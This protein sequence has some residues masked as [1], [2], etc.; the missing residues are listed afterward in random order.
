LPSGIIIKGIGGFYYVESAGAIYECKA[1]GIFRRRGLVP[2]AGDRVDFSLTDDRKKVGCIDNILPRQSLLARPTVANVNQVVVV[3]SVKS[4]SPDFMLVD[5]LLITAG[6]KEINVVVCINKIDLDVDEEY[7]KIIS[8]YEQTNYTFVL[9]S[10]KT[11][12]GLGQLKEALDNRISVFAGQSGVGKSTILNRIMSSNIMKTGEI[13]ERNDRGKHTTRHTELIKL[14]TNGYVADTPGFSSFDISEMR[15]DEL[16]LY[17]PEFREYLNSCKF[18]RCS[19]ISEPG[20]SIKE[21][22]GRRMINEGRYARYIELYNSLRQIKDY[23]TK[24]HS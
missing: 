7:K 10:S 15:Y 22:L 17:Y 13:S 6:Q 24:K 2:L 4:P 5:K 11:D 1:R 21:A 16:Q 9:S 12:L 23:E 14:G 8:S 19:H 20:C 3:I 18:A